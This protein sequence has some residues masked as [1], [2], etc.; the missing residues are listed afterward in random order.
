MSPRLSLQKP[1]IVASLSRPIDH[2]NGRYVVGV[3]HSGAPGSKKRKRS[4]VVVGVDGEGVNV[5]DVGYK[6]RILEISLI[7]GRYLRRE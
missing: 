4:E 5:Y 6:P 2:S 1:Y 3:V 7:C